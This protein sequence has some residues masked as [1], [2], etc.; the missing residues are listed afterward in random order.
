MI[1]RGHVARFC[2]R[3]RATE[4][5]EELSHRAT[6][7]IEVLGI[8]TEPQRK[9]AT[10]PQR[11]QGSWDRRG[12]AETTETHLLQHGGVRETAL[13]ARPRGTLDRVTPDAPTKIL[14]FL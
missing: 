11:T 13:H 4:D 5:T 2:H 7:D 8:A 6:Q 1:G 12:G 14:C 9:S 3:E 10:E